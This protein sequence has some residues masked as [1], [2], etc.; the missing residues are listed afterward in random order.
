MARKDISPCGPRTFALA[1]AAAALAFTASAMAVP[2]VF[3]GLDNVK[4]PSTR[5]NADAARNAFVA[6][7]G[8]ASITTQNFETAVV[9]D[10]PKPSFTGTLASGIGVTVTNSATNYMRISAG[11]GAFNTSPI[12]G[13]KYLE[14]LS[15]QGT[16]FFTA[17]FDQAVRA[18]G[19]Y[20]TDINDWKCC[21]NGA[22]PNTI[23]K[24]RLL[25]TS[26]SGTTELDLTPG[27][28]PIDLEDGNVE[29]F[30]VFDAVD[31]FTSIAIRSDANIPGGDGIGIDDV[32]ISVRSVPA[33]GTVAL[34]LSLLPVLG[35][36]R[37]RRV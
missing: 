1:A 16:T 23:G 17:A 8:G 22:S 11:I 27:S 25:L 34:L 3:F 28:D 31:P 24:L 30:G 7:V 21:N 12:S 35:F 29:F 2:M 13:S 5:P 10:L 20:I 33:P 36:V 4:L 32:M 15:D 6:A 14:T 37:S 18:I 19:F 9:G 26:A